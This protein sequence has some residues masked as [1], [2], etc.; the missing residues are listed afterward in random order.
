MTCGYDAWPHEKWI[1]P[2]DHEA[3]AKLFEGW[4]KTPRG[5]VEVRKSML[6]RVQDTYFLLQL[7]RTPDLAA[8]SLWDH[9][10]APSYYKGHVAMMGDAAHA[11]TPYQ[12]QGAGQAIED[13]CVLQ[14][15][16][17]RVHNKKELPN[18]LAAYDEVRRPR[19]QRNVTTSREA[20][21]LNFMRLKGV[22]GDI[23]KMRM[24]LDGRMHW[25]WNR[26]LVAQNDAAVKLFEEGLP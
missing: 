12:A 6:D 25:I 20:M 3:L 11:T 2:A 1:V 21:D 16:L 10:P 9:P 13:A 5:L 18:V 15:L 8:W 22:E 26:D 4:G 19:S 23:E 24:K 17:G 7:L 14:V